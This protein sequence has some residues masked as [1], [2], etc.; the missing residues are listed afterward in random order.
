M[1]PDGAL[2]SIYSFAGSNDSVEPFTSLAQDAE[3]N[4]YGASSN[5]AAADRRQYF[6][7]DPGRPAGHSLHLSIFRWPQWHLAVGRIDARGGRQFLRHDN[8]R[9]G[10]YQRQCL[11]ND[12]GGAAD[13]YFLL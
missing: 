9:R 4:F 1:T 13:Q 3:G 5:N 7:D 10:L 2:N 12:S 11:Q 8:Q 6:Q